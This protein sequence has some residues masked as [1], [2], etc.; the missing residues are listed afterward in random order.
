[1]KKIVLLFLIFCTG[2]QLL[3]D[4]G[5]LNS[6]FPF[7]AGF[8]AGEKCP[9]LCWLGINPGVTTE[10]QAKAILAASSQIRPIPLPPTDKLLMRWG[11]QNFND[12]D[13]VVEIYFEKGLVKTINFTGVPYKLGDF[14][15]LMGQP[16]KIRISVVRS[17]FDAAY[18]V[19][20]SSRRVMIDVTDST[21]LE[22]ED[23]VGSLYLNS[24][25]DKIPP[26][27]WGPDQPWPGYGDLKN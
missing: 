13:H 25:F 12:V 11:P 22:P 14:V 1:M 27:I 8:D 10:V 20:Y 19:F 23:S 9:Y 15:K 16:D 26:S 2:C 7:A 3:P 17:R 6:L 18:L 5:I 24:D 21:G 4:S